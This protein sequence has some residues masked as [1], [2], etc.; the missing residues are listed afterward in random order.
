MTQ[1]PQSK[2]HHCQFV[3]D[4]APRKGLYRI[5]VDFNDPQYVCCG[6]VARFRLDDDYDEWLCAEH[7]DLI[8]SYWYAPE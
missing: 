3:V 4:P 2:Q 1:A 6:A 5:A 7:Y 8:L